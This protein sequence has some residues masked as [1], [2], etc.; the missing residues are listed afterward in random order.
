MQVHIFGQNK[1]MI[2]SE[3][4]FK[5]CYCQINKTNMCACLRF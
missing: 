2:F 1:N 4:G 5:F 3:G